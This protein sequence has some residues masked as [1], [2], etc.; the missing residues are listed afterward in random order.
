MAFSPVSGSV[1][2]EVTLVVLRCSGALSQNY[3]SV[4]G[5]KLKLLARS[6]K[7]N[8]YFFSV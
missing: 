1:D 5:A 7:K 6:S 4:P 2:D 3:I 8:P